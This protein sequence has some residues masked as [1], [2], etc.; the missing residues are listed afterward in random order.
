MRRLLQCRSNYSCRFSSPPPTS[1]HPFLPCFIG[2]TNVHP[3]VQSLEWN[4]TLFRGR[5]RTVRWRWKM[6]SKKINDSPFITFLLGV[7]AVISI[8]LLQDKSLIPVRGRHFSPWNS[9]Q[10]DSGTN[11]GYSRRDTKLTT[12][13]QQVPRLRKYAVVSRFEL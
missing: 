3:L 10:T 12:Y 9:F 13:S 5:D 11:T 1:T 4:R 2:I 8:T 7:R 6:N